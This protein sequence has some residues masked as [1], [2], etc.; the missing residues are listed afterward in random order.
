MERRAEGGRFIDA[1]RK[2][3]MSDADTSIISLSSLRFHGESHT[4][5]AFEKMGRQNLRRFQ[6]VWL[7][8]RR[9]LDSFEIGKLS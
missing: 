3:G 5:F 8:N 9:K 2:A 4:L 7:P 1:L 6:I